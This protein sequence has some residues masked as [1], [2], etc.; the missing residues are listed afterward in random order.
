MLDV[1]WIFVCLREFEK[2]IFWFNIFDQAA[3]ILKSKLK[4]TCS[5]ILI[6]PTFEENGIFIFIVVFDSVKFRRSK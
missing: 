3:T 4:P 5:D 1:N 2:K 6:D